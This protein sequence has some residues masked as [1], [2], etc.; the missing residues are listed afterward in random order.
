MGVQALVTQCCV[1]PVQHILASYAEGPVWTKALDAS[2]ALPVSGGLNPLQ[3]ITAVGEHLFSLVPLLEQSQDS[4]QTSWLPRVLEA[5]LDTTLQKALQIKSL[6]APGA[7]QLM[8][9]LEYLQK[10][11]EALGSGAAAAEGAKGGVAA[12]LKEFIDALS[13]LTRQSLR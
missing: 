10:V 1:Q 11:T 7:Q 13:H 2:D 9:D 4:V 5:V 12:E 8:A 6:E 3:S